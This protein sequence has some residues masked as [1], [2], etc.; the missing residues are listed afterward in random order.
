MHLG[1]LGEAR[2]RVFLCRTG[3]RRAIQKHLHRLLVKD[4]NSVL[5]RKLT[6]HEAQAGNGNHHRTGDVALRALV[7]ERKKLVKARLRVFSIINDF[8]CSHQVHETIPTEHQIVK[9]MV[10]AGFTAKCSIGSHRIPLRLQA[11]N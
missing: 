1:F 4:L 5:L 7:L 11:L 9:G 2:E 3:Y 8:N 6:G 10:G